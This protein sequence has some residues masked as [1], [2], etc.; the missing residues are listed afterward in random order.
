[1]GELQETITSPSAAPSSQLSSS[2]TPPASASEPPR[3]GLGR[4]AGSRNRATIEREALQR[5]ANRRA[6]FG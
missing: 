3:R 5:V 4:P 1:M 6:I 2:T